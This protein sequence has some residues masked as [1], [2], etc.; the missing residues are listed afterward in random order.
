MYLCI[1]TSDTFWK[2]KKNCLTYCNNVYAYF[3]LPMSQFNLSNAVV[4]NYCILPVVYQ[5][6]CAFLIRLKRQ[7]QFM[8]FK[9]SIIDTFMALPIR[10]LTTLNEDGRTNRDEQT[11]HQ[12]LHSVAPPRQSFVIPA[13]SRYKHMNKYHTVTQIR[14]VTCD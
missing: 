8:S 3:K 1:S 13:L 11:N 2:Y 9:I 6:L 4:K 5:T 7:V 10:L 14:L 12:R